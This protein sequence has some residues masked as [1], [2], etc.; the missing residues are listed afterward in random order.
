MHAAIVAAA[1]QSVRIR[2]FAFGPTTVTVQVGDTVTWRNDPGDPGHTATADSGAWNSGNIGPGGTASVTFNT[3]GRFQYHCEYHPS[4]MTGTVVV[5]ARA[6]TGGQ[7]QPQTD[8]A[9]VSDPGS[10]DPAGEEGRSLVLVVALSAGLVAARLF[11]ARLR[12]AR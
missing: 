9:G 3:A 11:G 6:G 8:T 12:R 7:G 1:D 2:D 10:A 4:R 5:Q